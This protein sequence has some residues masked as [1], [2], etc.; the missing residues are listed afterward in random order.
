M[1]AMTFDEACTLVQTTG[2]TLPAN[3]TTCTRLRAYALFKQATLGD[4]NTG[5][6]SVLNV[7]RYAKWAEW[8]RL[9]GMSQEDAKGEYVRLVNA[10]CNGF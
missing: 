7:T 6:P 2:R 1:G 4:C 9:R 3:V 8:N 10:H 5:R